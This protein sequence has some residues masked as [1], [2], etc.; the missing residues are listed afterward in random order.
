MPRL[1]FDFRCLNGHAEEA[2]ADTS[3]RERICGVCGEPSSRE[4]S[5]PRPVLDPI[6]GH[7]PGA[8]ATWERNRQHQMAKEQKHLQN[9]GTYLPGQK[10]KTRNV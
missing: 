3:E 10:G 2:F 8:T 9:H 5:A 1:M 4:I 6:S 7:F